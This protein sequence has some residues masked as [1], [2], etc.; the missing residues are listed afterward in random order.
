MNIHIPLAT[1][2]LMASAALWAAEEPK[3]NPVVEKA[4][5]AALADAEKG[6]DAY[7][8]ILAKAT[9]KAAKD[10]E[11]AKADAMKRGDLASANELDARIK[12]L[13]EG[14]LEKLVME[15]KKA[16]GDLLGRA[17]ETAVELNNKSIIGKWIFTKGLSGSFVFQQDGTGV[18]QEKTRTFTWK[19]V[20]KANGGWVIAFTW[21]DDKSTDKITIDKTGKRF[22]REEKWEATKE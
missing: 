22:F 5:S 6:Y 10:L 4:M 15:R 8:A 1:L 19:S 2:T 16:E 21:D 3:P 7:R 20:G 12:E 17:A 14:G 18:W 13:K 9:D 11:K